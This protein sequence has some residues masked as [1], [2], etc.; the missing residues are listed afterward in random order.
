MTR[1]LLSGKKILHE[2]SFKCH[3]GYF[4]ITKCI[5]PDS[6]YMKSIDITEYIDD[7][8][9]KIGDE[10]NVV[11]TNKGQET[12]VAK[13]KVSTIKTITETNED[14]IKKI[15]LIEILN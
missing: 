12:L 3:N 10:Y 1:T 11:I 8:S 7:E 15:K 14:T 13:M 5:L 6:A 9:I 4:E 2:V